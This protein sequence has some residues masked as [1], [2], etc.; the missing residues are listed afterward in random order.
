MFFLEKIKET[1]RITLCFH[2]HLFILILSFLK[3]YLLCDLSINLIIVG[4]R[5]KI[6]LIHPGIIL[7]M[8]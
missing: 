3:L 7:K 6:F 4:Q 1:R 5:F 2:S 8:R